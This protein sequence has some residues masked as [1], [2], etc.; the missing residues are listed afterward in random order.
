MEKAQQYTLELPLN[1]CANICRQALAKYARQ[2]IKDSDTLISFEDPYS[3][4]HVICTIG[5]EAINPTTT[6]IT[7]VLASKHTGWGPWWEHDIDKRI[8]EYYR[9]IEL[10][11]ETTRKSWQTEK[12]QAGLL[13]PTCGKLVPGGTRFCPDD[14]TPIATVCSKCGHGNTPGAKFCAN[15]GQQLQ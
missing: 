10:N 13:C 14:G 2:I 1:I 5:L 8:S 15:C 12:Y 9:E 3:G 4:R 11:Y 6:E 7:I